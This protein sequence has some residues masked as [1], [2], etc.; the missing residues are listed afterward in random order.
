MDK[1]YLSII[2]YMYGLGVHIGSSYLL[3][4]SVMN[5][6][7]LAIRKEYHL[8]DL[9]KS[10]LLLKRSCN[11]I[12]NISSKKGNIYYS[13][14]DLKYLNWS[15]LYYLKNNFSFKN[16][17]LNFFKMIGGSFTNYKTCFL[18]FL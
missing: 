9:N 14:N 10:I 18:D 1:K 8:F 4:S 17:S 6:Y 11:V 3:H 2:K 7:V 16:V 5:R 12:Y 15:N 13:Y